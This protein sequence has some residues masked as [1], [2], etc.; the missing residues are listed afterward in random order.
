MS[1]LSYGNLVILSNIVTAWVADHN[2]FAVPAGWLFRVLKPM[3]V[4]ERVRLATPGG[5]QVASLSGRQ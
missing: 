4:D 3:F 1:D 5:D 2:V